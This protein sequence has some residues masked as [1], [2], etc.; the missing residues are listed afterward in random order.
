VIKINQEFLYV[1]L[2]KSKAKK[3]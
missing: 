1:R 3:E 2:F